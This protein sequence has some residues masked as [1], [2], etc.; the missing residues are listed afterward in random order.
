MNYKRTLFVVLLSAAWIFSL[1]FTG[2]RCG[3]V[4]E[5]NKTAGQKKSMAEMTQSRTDETAKPKRLARPVLTR[6]KKPKADGEELIDKS[7]TLAPGASISITGRPT[8]SN[9]EAMTITNPNLN[10]QQKRA[11]VGL[12]KVQ[13]AWKKKRKALPKTP[14]KKSYKYETEVEEK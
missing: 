2:C 12:K 1:I 4:E 7:R 10:L 9:E 5:K 8:A 11:L 6:K 14:A 3:R 13:E